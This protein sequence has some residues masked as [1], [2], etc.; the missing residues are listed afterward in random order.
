MRNKASDVAAHSFGPTDRLFFDTNV[1][2][3]L[4]APQPPHASGRVRAYSAAFKAVLA[5]GSTVLID[6]LVISEFINRSARLHY[7]L[8]GRPGDFKTFRNS[9]FFAGV[10]VDIAADMGAILGSA[11]PLDGDLNCADLPTLLTAFAAGGLDFNDQILTGICQR[12]GLAM[13]TDDGDFT[14]GGLQ[15]LT[16]NRRLL[17]ACP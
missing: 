7:E 3:L 16:A 6:V 1:W 14:E 12:H 4:Y 17:T 10:A 11:K 9:G 8:A 2:L 13:V 5:A 15:V